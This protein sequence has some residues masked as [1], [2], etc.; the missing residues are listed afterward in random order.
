MVRAKLYFQKVYLT[1][2]I[3]VDPIYFATPCFT[4]VL[5]NHSS[6]KICHN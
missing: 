6:N 3:P 5:I 2:A 1:F 4:Q